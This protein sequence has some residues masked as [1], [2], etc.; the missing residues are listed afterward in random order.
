[1]AV[2]P[3][4]SFRVLLEPHRREITLH[5][6]RMLGSL[7]DAE[8]MVQES[9]LRAWQRRDELRSEGAVR[10]WLY[11]IATN[12][13]LDQL[14]KARRRRGLPHWGA[15]GPSHSTRLGP[16]AD[17]RYWVEPAPDTLLEAEASAGQRPD[18]RVSQRESVGLAFIAAL[19]LLSPKQRAALLLVDVLGWVPQE[20]AAL[21]QSSVV[22][23]NSLLQRARKSV[24]SRRDDSSARTLSSADAALLRRFMR[25]WEGGDLDTLAALLAD[26]ALLSMPPQPEWFAGREAIRQFFAT[27]WS[28]V[29]GRRRLVPV[30]ANGGPAFA[31]YRQPAPDS[32]HEA[33][34]ITLV[35]VRGARVAQL[36]RFAFPRLFPLFGLP[37]Q[38][39]GEELEGTDPFA[40]AWADG[41][42][43]PAL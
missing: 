29:P 16:P 2:G 20:A 12:A 19:Q 11:K 9:L 15:V 30:G 39:P 21:L 42:R 31:L 35:A 5:C 27:V 26:D 28:A 43:S 38:I 10:A 22:S 18:A 8:E 3:D 14:L 4:E 33:V 23:I 13:C 1:M 7:Q 17:E 40:A 25:A 24:E 37:T 41:W 34:A 36:T 32:P 6:Y